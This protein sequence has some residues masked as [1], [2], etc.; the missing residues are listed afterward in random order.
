[1]LIGYNWGPNNLRQLFQQQGGLE[2]VPERPRQYALRIVQFGP[3]APVRRQEEL[4]T[5]VVPLVKSVR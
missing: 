1:M 3:E 5:V 4:E 2:D